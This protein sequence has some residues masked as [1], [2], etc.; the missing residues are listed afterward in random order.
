MNPWSATPSSAP[1]PVPPSLARFAWGNLV[2]L[3][4][5]A[6][7]GLGLRAYVSLTSPPTFV[8]LF[9]SIPLLTAH[10]LLGFLLLLA[11]A[12]FL[13]AAR[14][15]KMPGLTWRAAAVLLFVL[16]ALQEG[17]SY[18]YTLNNDYSTGMA[19]GFV[20]AFAFQVTVVA[21]LRR[22]AQAPPASAGGPA[23]AGPN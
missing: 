8:R 19:V 7:L 15:T 9:A 14:R 10:I 3:L 13:V 12:Y 1:R 11:T 20:L 2:A 21:R 18:T 5:E 23:G 4:L 17:F 22:P 16:L 6:I